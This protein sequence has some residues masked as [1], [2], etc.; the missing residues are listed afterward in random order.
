MLNGTGDQCYTLPVV[1]VTML[2]SLAHSPFLSRNLS[3]GPAFLFLMYINQ[4][5]LTAMANDQNILVAED[6]ASLFHSSL[7]VVLV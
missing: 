3:Y 5:R 1:T 2:S 6:D 4:G 7:V